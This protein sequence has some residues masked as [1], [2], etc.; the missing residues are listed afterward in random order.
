MINNIL[1]LLVYNVYIVET[2]NTVKSK[3]GQFGLDPLYLFLLC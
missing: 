1:I 3:L 2:V